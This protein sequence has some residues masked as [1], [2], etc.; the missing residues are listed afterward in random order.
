MEI[1]R[2]LNRPS[3]EWAMETKCTACGKKQAR[4]KCDNCGTVLCGDC[5]KLEI[6][7]CGAEDLTARYFCPTCK[8][9]PDVNPWGAYSD[10]DGKKADVDARAAVSNS[11]S[12]VERAAAQTNGKKL[13]ATCKEAVAGIRDGATIMVGGFTARG[14]PSNLLIALRDLGPKDLTVIRNDASG[15]WKNPIDVDILI[16][17][18]MVK[19]V[20]TCFAV[21][22][23]PKKVSV[24]ERAAMDGQV[25]VDL[26]PQ[27]TLAERIRAGGAGIG[28]FYTPTGVGTEA[29]AE[30]E[31]RVIDG[32][33][34]QL[35]YSLKADFALIKA[36]TSDTQGNLVYRKSARNFNPIMAMAAKTTVVET[37]NL[38]E[39]GAIDPDRIMTQ[40][41]FV[42]RIVHVRDGGCN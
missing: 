37:E 27:G 15:G 16:E 17:A 1:D 9:D 28:A 12:R 30:R 25:D 21:F 31:T 32:R 14:T 20:V 4:T 2:L 7:G 38:V 29:S 35:E 36:Y 11:P 3:K 34:M 24:L 8:D 6:W 42:D 18:G 22:G 39:T 41:L 23:S 26:V 13:Y 19:K 40:S 5:C 10:T 33:E